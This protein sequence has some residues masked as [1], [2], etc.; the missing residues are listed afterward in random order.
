M[1]T[2]KTSCLMLILASCAWLTVKAEE[3]AEPSPPYPN[4]ATRNRLSEDLRSLYAELELLQQYLREPR[5]EHNEQIMIRDL[6]KRHQEIIS[7]DLSKWHELQA[8]QF[9]EKLQKEIP[10][11][12]RYEPDAVTE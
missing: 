9:A 5:K 1:K 2:R 6:E 12:T 4:A 11:P 8:L 7:M 3:A 10:E